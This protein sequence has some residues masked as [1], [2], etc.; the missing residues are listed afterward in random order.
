MAVPPKPA[1]AGI[2]R[3]IVLSDGHV[4]STVGLWPGSHPVEGGGLYSC[5]QYQAWLH[6][7]WAAMLDEV[8]KFRPKPVVIYNGDPLQGIN[9]R[10]GQLVTNNIAS[11]VDAALAM[12]GPLRDLASRWYQ[13]RGTEWHEGK[14]AEH[15][16]LLARQLGGEADS[17]SGQYSW[18]ELYLDAEPSG[19]GPVMHFAHHVGCSSVPWYEATVP[20]RDTLMLLAELARFYGR[21]APNVRMVVR[22]HRHRFIHV[23]AP[24]DLH[25]VVTPAWQ[26]RGAFAYKKAASMLPQIGYVVIEWD[27]QDLVVKPRIFDLPDLHVEVVA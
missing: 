15:I 11:Q 2:R 6:E 10:D 13:V 24:P 26:L 4:G 23:D 1:K 21:R 25:V 8:R 22:S 7:C 12:Y 18:W 17:A 20:M 14:A 3:F 19:G 5:N 16:E 9:M 27:G